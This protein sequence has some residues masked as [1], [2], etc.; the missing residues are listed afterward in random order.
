MKTISSNLL[1]HLNGELTTLATIWQLT[2]TD[3]EIFRF[4]DHDADIQFEGNTYESSVGYNRSAV[5]NQAGLAVD[6]L[7]VTGFLDNDAITEADLRAGRYDFAEV[8]VGLV[9]WSD[10]SQGQ[11]RL[12]RGR[13]GEVRYSEVT[14]T[15]DA[16]LRGLT[17]AYSQGA[18]ELYQAECRADLGDSRCQVVIDPPFWA[19]NTDYAVGD[20][21]DFPVGDTVTQIALT[22]GSFEADAPGATTITGWTT[23]QGTPIVRT[24]VR[25]SVTGARV[26]SNYVEGNGADG[27]TTIIEQV[28]DL[29]ATY[30]DVQLDSGNLIPYTQF[31]RSSAF[32]GDMVQGS[33]RYLDAVGAEISRDDGDTTFFLGD[34]DDERVGR[35]PTGTTGLPTGTRQIAIRLTMNLV[36]G[37]GANGVVDGVDLFIRDRT[38]VDGAR[39]RGN[40]VYRCTVAGRSDEHIPAFSTTVGATFAEAGL[41][42]EVSWIV[43]NSFTRDGVVTAVVADRRILTISVNEPRA[44]DDWF[45][46]G[47]VIFESGLNAELAMEVKDW[48]QSNSRLELFLPLSFTIAVGDRFRVYAGCDKRL[49]T[50]I[51]KFDNVVNFR[52]EPYV[53]GQDEFYTYPDAR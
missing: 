40:V 33:L 53:P 2:R 18:L 31:W 17:D 37:A 36:E 12:R 14:G 34:W 3:G 47:A 41:R 49:T 4:T 50:C 52:G 35:D 42:S 27:V 44:V 45:N 29:T 46:Y 13:L 10:P 51:N 16:E 38:S 23:I 24:G 7:N 21:V 26:G 48:T 28:V 1:N 25:G 19:G 30:T 15:F 20:V 8:R 11:L 32:A 22:N 43:D 39:L 5:D 6:N 9:N